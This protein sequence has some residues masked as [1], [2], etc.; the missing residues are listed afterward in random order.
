MTQR[1]D[2][3]GNQQKS[4]DPLGTGSHPFLQTDTMADN[5]ARTSRA[6]GWFN[7]YFKNRCHHRPH[8]VKQ[9]REHVLF[10]EGRWR[11]LSYTTQK[12][13]A[14]LELAPSPQIPTKTAKKENKL[15]LET[16]NAL[17]PHLLKSLPRSLQPPKASSPLCLR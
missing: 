2:D 17:F 6:P 7:P 11:K 4:R 13:R 16:R 3:P 10:A 12:N 9:P 8:K 14:K 1:A 5:Q 15:S